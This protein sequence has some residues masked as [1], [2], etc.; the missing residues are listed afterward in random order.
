[1]KKIL[2][3]ALIG[4]S[5]ATAT[6]GLRKKWHEFHK[7][8][9]AVSASKALFAGACGY[10]ALR[11]MYHTFRQVQIFFDVLGATSWTE[12][13]EGDHEVIGTRLIEIIPRK[14]LML[15]ICPVV[16]YIAFK[17]AYHDAQHV[18]S[19]TAENK[20]TDG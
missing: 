20:S 14:I 6:A 4:L 15:G 2:C 5:S 10:A 9:K 12:D 11:E 13:L 8:N 3:C 17:Q 18:V 7:D 16:A 19:S 1:M